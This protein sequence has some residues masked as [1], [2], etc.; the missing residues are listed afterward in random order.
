LQSGNYHEDDKAGLRFILRQP[1]T[2]SGKSNLECLGLTAADTATWQTSEGWIARIQNQI[3]K[4]YIDWEWNTS[5]PC[6]LIRLEIHSFAD[7]YRLSGTLNTAFFQELEILNVPDCRF[8]GLN[9][10]DNTRLKYL[11]C[12]YNQLPNLDISGNVLLAQLN[13]AGNVLPELSLLSNLDLGVL[14]CSDNRLSQLDVSKQK[15]LVA[16]YCAENSIPALALKNNSNLATLDCSNNLINNLDLTQNAKMSFLSCSGNPLGAGIGLAESGDSL[17]ALYAANAGL[18]DLSLDS[19]SGLLALYLPGNRLEVLNV[20]LNPDLR[21]LICSD[22]DLSSLDLSQ[23]VRLDWLNCSNNKLRELKVGNGLSSLFFD[24]NRLLFSSMQT[25]AAS[26]YSEISGV[27]QLVNA[28]S[29]ETGSVIDLSGEYI[30]H[31][32]MTSYQWYDEAGNPATLPSAGNGSFLADNA[33]LYQ[34][35]TCIMTNTSYPTLTVSY[36][37][38]IVTQGENIGNKEVQDRLVLYP[39]PFRNVLHIQSENPVKSVELYDMAGR[40]MKSEQQANTLYEIHADDLPQGIYI[41]KATLQNGGK[42]TGKV[43]KK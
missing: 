21:V 25:G 20:S 14:N 3:G 1:S 38:R 26:E 39:N 43:E 33:Y 11:D 36:S 13:C 32:V 30:I 9:I 31:G 29:V 16:L 24:N 23:N 17:K 27:S 18:Q 2:L 12:S 35:L 7:E 4:I 40:L 15:N 6:R 19:S 34:T 22:N 5:V 41:L 42:I 8:S 37:V 10:I 28:G